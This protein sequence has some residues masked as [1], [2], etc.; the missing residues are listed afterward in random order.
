MSK[1]KIW[2][3]TGLVII[4]L[5][6]GISSGAIIANQHK[7][8]VEEQSDKNKQSS[9]T[10]KKHHKKTVAKS[11]ST[12]SSSSTKTANEQ[13]DDLPQKTQIALLINH[14]AVINDMKPY[15]NTHY[16]IYMGTKN[17]IVIYDDG[18]GA[19]AMP[20]HVTLVTDNQD[21][22]FTY[23][24]V[25]STSSGAL[26][27]ASNS[28]WENY[29]TT[30][31]ATLLEEYSSSKATIDE[32]ASEVDLSKSSETFDYVP[33][34]QTT[35][36]ATADDN[37]EDIESDDDYDSNDD[38]D[39]DDSDD[40]DDADQSDDD[41]YAKKAR[42]PNAD[43]YLADGTHMHNDDQGNSYDVDTGDIIGKGGAGN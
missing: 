35:K 25:S 32:V 19:G 36:P 33:V 43:W 28:W 20:D 37:S 1:K 16:S 4:M 18:E 12:S 30:Q 23:A 31:K 34:N 13:F 42:E 40:S 5:G 2:G 6:L 8:A 38:T 22:S 10:S 15:T 9:G 11:S 41:Y 14:Q 3:L 29:A 26:A 39:Y 17:K 24:S 21:G 7:P 27:T